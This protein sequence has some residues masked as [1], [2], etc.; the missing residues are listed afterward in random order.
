MSPEPS[1]SLA[2]NDD[3]AAPAELRYTPDEPVPRRIAVLR[4]AIMAEHAARFAD[5][6]RDPAIMEGLMEE[7]A[8]AWAEVDPAFAEAA[9]LAP[10]PGSGAGAPC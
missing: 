9:G 3:A 10:A 5:P 7:F 4:A 8:A 6:E 1:D 2:A